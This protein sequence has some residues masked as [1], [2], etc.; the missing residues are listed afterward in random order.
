MVRAWLDRTSRLRVPFPSA[1]V[2]QESLPAPAEPGEVP[3][4]EQ[5]ATLSQWCEL[6][7]TS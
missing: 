7:H 1:S 2:L 3:E 5:S 6:D 4:R